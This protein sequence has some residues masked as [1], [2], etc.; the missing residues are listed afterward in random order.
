MSNDRT[1]ESIKAYREGQR[2]AR[3]GLKALTPSEFSGWWRREGQP[4]SLIDKGWAY[5]VYS[6]GYDS[7][8]Q[9]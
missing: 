3:E 4:D 5:A 9:G 2:D 1:L 7:E 8:P 6:L